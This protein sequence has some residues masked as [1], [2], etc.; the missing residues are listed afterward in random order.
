MKARC[1]SYLSVFITAPDGLIGKVLRS[2]RA[3]EAGANSC[4]FSVRCSV[5]FKLLLTLFL[6]TM[7]LCGDQCAA[8]PRPLFY[9]FISFTASKGFLFKSFSFSFTPEPLQL[10]Q[11]CNLPAAAFVLA[12]QEAGEQC[13]SF[14]ISLRTNEILRQARRGCNP[15]A[16]VAEKGGKASLIKAQQNQV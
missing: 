6:H 12:F 14:L 5:S 3:R 1:C 4:L 13:E 9:F 8:A 7:S 16:Q 11:N 15:T 2:R 10:R